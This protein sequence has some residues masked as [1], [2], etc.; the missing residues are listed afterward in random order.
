M[1]E[2]LTFQR[3]NDLAL[4]TEFAERLRQLGIYCKIDNQ[5]APFDVTFANNVLEDDV[6]IKLLPGDFDKANEALD[7]YYKSLLDT[8]E[9]DY[10]LF[11]F[12]DAELMEIIAKPD[13]WNRFDFQLAQKLL[14]ERGEGVT[15]TQVTHL[16]Q[17]RLEDLS[18]AKNLA[19]FW[20]FIAYL[21]P[22]G[23]YILWMHLPKSIW[24]FYGS[25]AGAV[26]GAF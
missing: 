15:G 21:L 2:L 19:A 18:K 6:R 20:L 1:E 10:Y 14:Q 11:Q 25:P 22:L 5:S 12:T 4:A 13:E 9:P 23:G 16:Q 3:F 26:V 24:I 17:E 7:E 8:V